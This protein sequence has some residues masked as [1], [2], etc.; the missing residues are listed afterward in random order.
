MEKLKAISEYFF[1]RA[2][3]NVN[4]SLEKLSNWLHDDIETELLEAE[5]SGE[6][7]G[8]QFINARENHR[9][10][11]FRSIASVISVHSQD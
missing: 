5:K 3:L 6:R 10:G 1:V 8:Q 4:T 7:G 11:M 2:T 9:K